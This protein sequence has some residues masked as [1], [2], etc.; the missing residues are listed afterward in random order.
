MYIPIYVFPVIILWYPRICKNS[1]L[2]C[3]QPLKSDVESHDAPLMRGKKSKKNKDKDNKYDVGISEI[4]NIIGCYN[5]K[6]LEELM[7]CN[8]PYETAKKIIRK[9][10]NMSITQSYPSTKKHTFL[11]SFYY[12]YNLW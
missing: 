7:K 6:V 3:T 4:L 10:I 11:S 8:V 9:M 5:P 1:I 12:N 2:Y